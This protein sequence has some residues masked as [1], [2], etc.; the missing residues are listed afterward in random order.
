M[1]MNA[2]RAAIAGRGEA[3]LLNP[4]DTYA[5]MFIARL[6][7]EHGIRTIA[8]HSSWRSR[9]PMESRSP[10]LGSSAVSA[11]F[12]VPPGGVEALAGLLRDRHEV[13]A[14][15]PHEEGAVVP[16]ARLADALGLPWSQPELT[17][18]L[19]S[20][21]KV[22]QR[23]AARDPQLRLNAFATVRN[24]AELEDWVVSRQ[25]SS[26]VLKPDSG[27]G[28]RD[29]SFFTAGDSRAGDYLH[30]AVG[31]VLAEEFIGGDE[32]FVNG[33]VGASGEPLVVKVGRYDRRLAN[34]RPNVAFSSR[35]L[36]TDAPEFGMLRD[37]AERIILAV[38]LRF[39][40]F[41]LEAKID[42]R[43]PCLIE[44]GARLPG[45]LMAVADSWRHGPGAD[46]VG[47]ALHG[48]LAIDSGEGLTLDWERADAHLVAQVYGVTEQGG[49]IAGC[50][51]P[52]EVEHLA[53][54]LYWIRQP[55]I[56]SVVTP[57]VD[58]VHKPWAATVWAPDDAT[59]SERI[60]ALRDKMKLVVRQQSLGALATSPTLARGRVAKYIHAIPRPHVIEAEL[61]ARA[62]LHRS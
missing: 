16:L 25:V 35:A 61:R 55:D 59:L 47:A 44:V 34:G 36:G 26:F 22:K 21:T 23:I 54:F 31:P 56:G 14:V 46:F 17:P 33:Y 30:S 3:V 1:E 8:L 52:S 18:V 29:V 19:G 62:E 2:R 39:S 27:S 41:H 45:S 50:A 15:V 9:L 37:Y 11:H 40:P 53:G 13:E 6:Y 32:F 20:K 48:Y 51:D 38:G 60:D 24:A 57:T 58:L 7:F 12:M 10:L 28:N 43:G 5:R 4:Y 42:H 49:W